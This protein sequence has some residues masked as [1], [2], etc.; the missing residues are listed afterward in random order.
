MVADEAIL[1][2]SLVLVAIG[3]NFQ[4]MGPSFD[5]SRFGFPL[6]LLGATS[7]VLLPEDLNYPESEV[8]SSIIGLVKWAAPFFLGSLLVLRSSPTYGRASPI[9][10]LLGWATIGSSWVIAYLEYISVSSNDYIS[11]IFSFI[12]ILLGLI[13]VYIGASKSERSIGLDSYSDPLSEEERE[14][15]KTILLRRLGGD[16]NGG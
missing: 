2:S 4:R 14:L 5:R 12:G 13:L 1:W 10:L 15:V 11:G 3:Y 9:G 16:G 8:H 7:F 6:A